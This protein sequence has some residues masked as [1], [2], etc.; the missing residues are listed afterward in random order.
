MEKNRRPSGVINHQRPLRCPTVKNLMA[1]TCMVCAAASELSNDSSGL[2]MT[3][4][5]ASSAVCLMNLR[6]D[7]ISINNSSELRLLFQV[8]ELCTCNLTRQDLYSRKEVQELEVS[9]IVLSCL[10]VAGDYLFEHFFVVSE[11]PHEDF[12]EDGSVVRSSFDVASTCA[13]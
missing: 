6:R 10:R 11:M 5:A 7:K 4:K 2:A 1:F 12:T 8:K 13:K 3:V 9:G